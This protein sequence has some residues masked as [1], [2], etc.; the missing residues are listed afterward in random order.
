MR[1]NVTSLRRGP[2]RYLRDRDVLHSLAVTLLAFV[3]SGGLLGLV[4]LVRVW[5]MARTRATDT[6]NARIALV[7]GR[8]L[9]DER[10]EDDYRHRLE[11]VLA[12]AHQGLVDRV[13]LLGGGSGSRLSEA[14]AGAH[15]LRAQ[16]WPVHV[17]L[18]LE[19]SSIDSLENLRHAREL[20]RADGL[21]PVVLVTSRYHLARCQLLADRLGLDAHPVAAEPELPRHTRYRL[22]MVLEAAYL[23][24]IDVGLRWAHLIGHERMTA[25]LR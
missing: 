18:E 20:L 1:A 23:M 5:R 19:Q 4:Y 12:L 24:W 10:P 25:R 8:R 17:P 16:G 7:F 6:G 14:Q 15:W 9:Q 13:L 2:W 3:C 21:P 22:R 11:R